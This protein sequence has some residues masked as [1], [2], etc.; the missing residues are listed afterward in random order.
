MTP[1][2]KNNIPEI[3]SPTVVMSEKV[4]DKRAKIENDEKT[5][6]NM[7]VSAR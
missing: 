3:V 2:H 5:M 6:I 4:F 1:K 7:Y